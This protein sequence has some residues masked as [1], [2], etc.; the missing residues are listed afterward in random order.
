MDTKQLK[1]LTTAVVD[2]VEP[3]VDSKLDAVKNEI[4]ESQ[5]NFATKE[6]VIDAVGAKI[7][8]SE[9]KK[10]DAMKIMSSFIKALKKNKN[11]SM[12]LKALPANT[13]N[14]TVDADGGFLV[15]EEFMKG[16]IDRMGNYGVIRSNATVIPM[17]REIYNMNIIAALPA[18]GYVDEGVAIPKTKVQF[19]QK[20]LTARKVAA[21]LPSTL[22]L[23]EDATPDNDVWN[24]LMNAV[25]KAL[26]K[27]EDS[28]GFAKI[29][30][31]AGTNVETTTGIA[32]T[33]VSYD[34]VVD[35]VYNIDDTN[36]SSENELQFYGSR[37][38]LGALK[39][40]KD[41]TGQPIFSLDG[42]DHYIL[43]YKYNIVPSLPKA[44]TVAA[45]TKFLIF[46]DMKSLFFGDRKQVTLDIGNADGDFE[47]YRQTLRAVERYDMNLAY[48]EVFSILKTKA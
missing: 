42:K 47:A 44:S 8:N 24:I 36:I 37:N 6:D 14:E 22:E 21:L 1:E 33:S 18:V 29:I 32:G 43:G 48:P 23:I 45:N 10:E 13:A 31:S 28:E 11:V 35:M 5:K 16:V 9:E 30:G 34:N 7:A 25:T 41:T 46:G 38:T 3:I 12:A 20:N 40:I 17:S 27:F 15:P 26:L 39:K 19:A 4:T 2:A